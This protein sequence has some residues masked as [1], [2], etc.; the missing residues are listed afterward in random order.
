MPPILLVVLPEVPVYSSLEAQSAFAEGG[1]GI[2]VVSYWQ[3]SCSKS[4]DVY[5][6]FGWHMDYEGVGSFGAQAF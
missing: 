2:S 3:A 6:L 4:P 1:S 5:V